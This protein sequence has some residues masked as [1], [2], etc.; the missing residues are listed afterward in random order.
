MNLEREG[1]QNSAHNKGITTALID[2]KG[3]RRY[4]K[5]MCAKRVLKLRQS[6]QFPWK[7]HIL[8]HKKKQKI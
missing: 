6:G 4:Y 2:I 5:Q 1:R 8:N 7:T 3:Q